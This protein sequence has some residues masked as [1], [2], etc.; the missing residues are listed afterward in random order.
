MW[1]YI[2]AYVL[3]L[4]VWSIMSFIAIQHVYTYAYKTDR[5]SRN[6]TLIYIVISIALAINGMR[7]LLSIQL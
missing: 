6:L 2:L 4:V 3:I 7:V 5:L 1:P